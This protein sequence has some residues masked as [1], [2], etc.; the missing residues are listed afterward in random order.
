MTI[1]DYSFDPRWSGT[2]ATLL[3]TEL[4]GSRCFSI[5]PPLPIVSS[6]SGKLS[7]NFGLAPEP[8]WRVPPLPASGRHRSRA[9]QQVVSLLSGH[10]C[11]VIRA[12]L[13]TQFGAVP[14]DAV[15]NQF[16]ARHV[17]GSIPK[18]FSISWSFSATLFSPSACPIGCRRA[19]L[20]P[21]PTSDS[22]EKLVV[23]LA[24]CQALASR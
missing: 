6:C 22:R 18:L 10:L 13:L 3:F 15:I 16:A 24:T 4:Y 8:G 7:S 2:A 12:S 14:T 9:R 19:A 23:C 20:L 17:S 11:K 5:P 1:P 21:M